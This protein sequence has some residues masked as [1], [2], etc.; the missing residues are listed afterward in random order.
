[1]YENIYIEKIVPVLD[2]IAS[3]MF[4]FLVFHPAIYEPS[5]HGLRFTCNKRKTSNLLKVS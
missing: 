5:N 4:V 1:M 2:Y 3:I